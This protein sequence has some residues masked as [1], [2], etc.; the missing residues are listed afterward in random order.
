MT[1]QCPAYETENERQLIIE[2][3]FARVSKQVQRLR[4]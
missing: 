3:S 1:S 2:L 4:V